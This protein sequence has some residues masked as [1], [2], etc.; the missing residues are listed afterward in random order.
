MVNL[1]SEA[2]HYA[3]KQH[4]NQKYGRKPYHVHLFDVVSV[5]RRF[6][7][8]S[9]LP[10]PMVD[11]A[12]MHDVIEDTDKTYEEISFL[13][14]AKTADLVF[15]VTNESGDNR[16]ERHKKTYIK[17]RET[18]QAIILKL[19]DRIANIEQSISFNRV[20]RRPHNLFFMYLKEWDD[21]QFELRGR[22]SG[23]SLIATAMWN[24][25]DM[26]FELGKKKIEKNETVS[27]NNK[28]D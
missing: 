7:D 10:Q 23:E 3:I 4:G 5:L 28:R 1:I 25:L 6:Y 27:D 20:G 17:I 11:A 14:G 26:L 13:F 18:D 8:W 21:F 19:A 12:W 15:A 9:E 2:T 22:C 16:K 24:H